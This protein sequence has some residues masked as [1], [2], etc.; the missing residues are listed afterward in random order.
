MNAKENSETTPL[1]GDLAYEHAGFWFRSSRGNQEIRTSHF[2]P[3]FGERRALRRA[4]M[5]VD[6][7]PSEDIPAEP[8]GLQD[9][10]VTSLA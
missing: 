7:E 9:I 5:F 6:L 2:R 4:R 8:F 1:N 10:R 3:K